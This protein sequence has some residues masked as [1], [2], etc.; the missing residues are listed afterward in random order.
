MFRYFENLVDPYVDY[1][2]TDTPPARVG[3]FIRSYTEAFRGVFYLG[4]ALAVVVAIVEVWLV[5]Y[6]GRLVDILRTTPRE[7]AWSLYGTELLIVAFFILFLRPIIYGLHVLLLN[8]AMMPNVATTV[9]WRSHR[10]VL[11]Q[12]IGWFENDFAGR[13]A[14]RIMQTP[15]AVGEVVFQILD[16]MAFAIAYTIGA[17]ILMAS[18]DAW[19]L[20]PL[21]AWLIP[22]LVLLRWVVQRIPKASEDASNARSKL[23]GRI[24]DSYTNVHAVKMFAHHDRELAYAKEAID[25]TR[26]T[27]AAEM[28]L[29]TIMDIALTIMNGVPDRRRGGLCD[30]PLGAGSLATIGIVASATAITLRLSAMSGWIMWAVSNFFQQLGVVKEGMETIAQP[31]DLVD[32]PKAQPIEFGRGR[33]EFQGVSHHYGKKTGGLDNVDLVIE[34]GEKVGLVG[35]SGAGKSTLVKLMLRFYD[36]ETG[37]I[38]IDGQDI[39]TLTQDSLRQSIGMVQQESALLHRTVRENILYGNAPTRRM[40]RSAM[41]PPRRAAA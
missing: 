35:P 38:L 19:L 20:L 40:S 2:S 32:A 5:Y 31:V 11:R 10:H 25:D 23:T 26:S 4:A 18:A 41:P 9:R 30:L 29:Y 7:E 34:P 37:R 12:S 24:V 22:Y 17:A 1:D 8:N 16:A 14:N 28:R 15:S 36:V 39:A 27:F 3:P 21:M 13:I 6:L 33:V